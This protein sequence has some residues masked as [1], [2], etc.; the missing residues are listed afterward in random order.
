MSTVVNSY[1]VDTVDSSNMEAET[2][3]RVERDPGFPVVESG[4]KRSLAG[5][6][7]HSTSSVVETAGLQSS[8]E[9]AKKTATDVELGHTGSGTKQL[10]RMSADSVVTESTSHGGWFWSKKSAEPGVK[11]DTVSGTNANSTS[12]VPVIGAKAVPKSSRKHKPSGRNENDRMAAADCQAGVANSSSS[13]KG[14]ASDISSVSSSDV[15][16]SISAGVQDHTRFSKH[17]SVDNPVTS[18]PVRG[19]VGSKRQIETNPVRQISASS[20]ATRPPVDSVPGSPLS[21]AFVLPE[22]SIRS[23][24]ATAAH[25]SSFSS[26]PS[27]TASES[28]NSVST[29]AASRQTSTVNIEFDEGHYE[30]LLREKA[31]LEGRLEV[32]ERE[33]SEML[34]QQ[35]E[36]KQRAAVFEQ[37]TKTFMSTSQALDADRSAMA[38]DLETLRQNRSRLEAVIV[39]AHKLLEEKEQE[40]QTLERD[41]ELARLAGEKHLERVADMR[42]DAASRDATVHD[43]KAKITELYVQSQTSDQ[44]RQV[45]EGELAAVQADVVALMEAKE[46]YANQ[47]RATQK[48][49]TRLQQEA[50][51]ARAETITANVASERLRA[52]NA[53]VKRNLTEVEQRVLT[54]KQTLA[55]HLEDIEADMLAREAALTVQL[56]QANE[57][58]DHPSL[59]TSHD[60]TEELSCLKAELGRN[61]E[62]MEAIQRENMELSR[63][64]A[65]S[66][67][68]V[69]DR[70]ESVKSLEHDRENAELRAEAA[71][72]GLALRAA[73]IQ[74]LESER[75]ELQLQLDSA[76]RERLM[77]DQSLQTLRR[78]TAV[79][80]TG[81]RRMQQD[82]AA[83]T[84]E[85]EK[86]SSPR[87]RGSDEQLSEVWPNVEAAA[88]LKSSKGTARATVDGSELSS[89]TFAD[90]EIQSDD[91]LDRVDGSVTQKLQES[92]S[93]VTTDTQ[94]DEHMVAMVTDAAEVLRRVDDIV[95]Q[96]EV[97]YPS[98]ETSGT[99][100]AD[101]G[102]RIIEQPQKLSSD[103]EARLELE[104]TEKSDIIDKLNKELDRVKACLQRTQLDLDVANKQRHA[105][106]SEKLI[107][108]NK[109]GNVIMDSLVLN[110]P[111]DSFRISSVSDSTDRTGD[112]A[113][114][115]K[116]S[117]YQR[118]EVQLQTDEVDLHADELRQQLG[119]L[120]MRLS[121][122]QEE[123]DT[124][125]DQKLHLET[126]KATVELEASA[127]AE[128]LCEVEKLLQQ[129]QD[130]LVRLEQQL[131]EAD[132]NS[133]VHNGAVKRL[134]SEKFTLQSQLDELTLVHHKDV[135]RLKSKV[136]C[137]CCFYLPEC[138]SS[139]VSD[140]SIS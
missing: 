38:V 105:L 14:Y 130:D 106:E 63:R 120:E 6:E 56:R 71:E 108:L 74:R 65:L 78:D 46:W 124:T 76:S 133:E 140:K 92:V 55:R 69:I 95:L 18:T 21:Y 75:S 1:T 136:C 96:S 81:F 42:R 61:S 28:H 57:S 60:E 34:R 87:T 22:T 101:V 58:S 40:V 10:I 89:I 2:E 47:L 97:V 82:L 112:V 12:N 93:V 68:C 51:A 52:E 62:R 43:L 45:L 30:M 115:H 16:N 53:R 83:K 121:T 20:S 88:G 23:S 15:E 35:A 79:L 44:S 67:Q 128:R 3:V 100:T 27:E 19:N 118:C 132:S 99:V 36:L 94:T 90:K 102:S 98:V 17:S 138:Q 54:E 86:L 11:T 8:N 119:A 123:L 72:Q 117:L 70:D 125:L 111:E 32:M 59:V 139:N 26:I 107:D 110:T 73:D 33:N 91:F 4:D 85:V 104:L 5:S 41:L 77:I 13:G 80:E 103:T 134:E 66:Q 25:T 64:L 129:T 49:R 116:G 127:T 9:L 50:A 122:L 84:A 135:S 29:P 7:P 126:A 39:D 31:G 137:C 109:E 48:D 24:T 113:R 131:S 37:Q 114:V